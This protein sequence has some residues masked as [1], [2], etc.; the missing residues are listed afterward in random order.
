MAW[1]SGLLIVPEDP[2]RPREVDGANPQ[3][4]PLRHSQYP[5]DEWRRS[6]RRV[7]TFSQTGTLGDLINRP[8]PAVL[9]LFQGL[10]CG[11]PNVLLDVMLGHRKLY[12][13]R[14]RAS[15]FD[16]SNSAIA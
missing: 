14:A 15:V 11:I 5:S 12:T 16:A 3:P 8:L 6:Y 1:A 10:P 4:W 2:P 7:G 9:S 13:A